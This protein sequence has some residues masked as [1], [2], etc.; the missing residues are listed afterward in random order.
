MKIKIYS[1]EKL[2]LAL[3]ARSYAKFYL[4]EYG[5][6]IDRLFVTGRWPGA[7]EDEVTQ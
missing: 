3:T 2:D 1:G 7:D 6:K 5:N 4:H